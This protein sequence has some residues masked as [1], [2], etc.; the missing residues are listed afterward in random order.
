VSRY[1]GSSTRVYGPRSVAGNALA[2]QSH[3]YD[4]DLGLVHMRA[5]VLDPFTG[6][7]LEPDPSGFADSA[8]PY[9]GL[10][11]DPINLRDPTGR[12]IPLLVVGAVLVA[13]NFEDFLAGSAVISEAVTT[14]SHALGDASAEVGGPF[15][16]AVVATG[17]ETIAGFFQAA[18]GLVQFPLAV[19]QMPVELGEG[20]AQ[21]VEGM[22][23]GNVYEAA[24][25]TSRVITS[26]AQVFGT[27][28][29]LRLG[30]RAFIRPPARRSPVRAEPGPLPRYSSRGCTGG[31]CAA[32]ES[33]FASGTLVQGETLRT[34]EDVR[35]GDRVGTWGGSDATSVDSSWRV[36]DLE[37]ESAANPGHMAWGTLLRSSS[38]LQERAIE[39]IGDT[40]WLEVDELGMSGFGT[41]RSIR[42]PPPVTPGPGRVVLGTLTHENSD[43]WELALE[44]TSERLVVTGT[45]PLYSLDRGAWVRVDALLVGESLV[46]MDGPR[47]VESRTRREGTHRV[48]NLTVEEEHE[49]LVGVRGVRAHNTCPDVGAAAAGGATRAFGGLSRAAEFGLKPYGQLRQAIQGTGLQAHHLIEQRF[50]GVMGQN[51][52]QMM[53]VAVTPAEHQAFTNAWRA[54]IPYGPNGTGAATREMVMDAARQIYSSHPEILGALGL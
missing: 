42:G 41:V 23:T 8:N 5:R 1:G 43:V 32:P 14:H 45:H 15:V 49:Y 20:S 29:G 11:N 38:W 34:I 9:A 21:V 40:V 52:R 46:T 12:L 27:L 39:S 13:T 30:A 4:A 26:G 37:L 54:L 10:A 19:C 31:F 36:I 2:F 7:F 47:R 24:R 16:G 6:Q 50:A 53:S 25:G 17:V 35:V 51:A 18:H 22:R 44:G 28:L 3:L 33:C 48:Y